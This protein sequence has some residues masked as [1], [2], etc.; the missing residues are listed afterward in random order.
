MSLP[1][2]HERF[3]DG[4]LPRTRSDPRIVGVAA[5]GSIANGVPDE[6]SDIDLVLAIEDDEFDEVMRGRLALIAAW[7]P[8]VAGFTGEHVGEPRLIISL[9]GPQALH[10]DFK[11][12][13]LTDF[14]TRVDGLRVL[15]ERDGR[16]SAALAATPPAP[17]RLDL[18][19]IE[20]RFWV[21]IH[22]GATKLARGELLE[23]IGF[24]AFLRETVFGPL[25]QHRHGKLLQGV[26]R[27]EAID[28]DAAARLE[29]TLCGSDRGEV[30]K[31]LLACVEL[32]RQ[33]TDDVD[34]AFDRNHDAAG[35]ATRYL[36][37]VVG[38][39]RPGAAE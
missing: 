4:L 11:F 31:A 1:D 5:G 28:P 32:Y 14:A 30:G 23:A 37:E 22:Y 13:R 16:L 8:L 29:A 26:R 33:W 20:D 35:L 34:V 18:Q 15:W 10:V 36:N 12:V 2:V 21:W 6:Y 17:P 25:I 9:M 7:S 38:R 24:I 19:W 27:L 39:I 3:L